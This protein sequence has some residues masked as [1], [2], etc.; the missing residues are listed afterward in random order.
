LIAGSRDSPSSGKFVRGAF[1]VAEGVTTELSPPPGYASRFD[2]G[3]HN[4]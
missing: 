2:K 1:R 3:E 4:P